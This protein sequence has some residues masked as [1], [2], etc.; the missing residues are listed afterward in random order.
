MDF[1]KLNT[2]KKSLN[3][4]YKALGKTKL[5]KTDYSDDTEWTLTK[6]K[7]GNGSA[8]IRFIPSP[9]GEL[10]VEIRNHGFKEN[11]SWFIEN[12]PKTLDWD[13]GCPVCEH[14]KALQKGRDWEK[15]STAE[16]ATIKPLFAKTSYYANVL[17]E[18]DP[19][20]PDNDGKVFKF[21]FGKKLLE[22]IAARAQDDPLDGSEGINVFDVHEGAALKLKCKK[23]GG[24]LNYD[25]ST[26]DVSKPLLGG[27]EDKI[28]ELIKT[29]PA[30]G[31]LRDA[32]KFKSYEELLKKLNR[33]I[34]VSGQPAPGNA[35]SEKEMEAPSKE[36]SP[37]S[38]NEEDDTD[39]SFEYF[40]SLAEGE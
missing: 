14:A 15:I 8:K 9:D 1:S 6:D 10:F 12:C 19:A 21:R 18:V 32:D 26:W 2:G 4:L 20:N 38:K 11:G 31:S 5:V 33:V 24:F 37:F 27:N 28:D 35:V 39:D 13:N 7:D 3:D 40:K 16:Q 22:K 29:G 30:I 25:D 34:G 36:E 23:V 17:V